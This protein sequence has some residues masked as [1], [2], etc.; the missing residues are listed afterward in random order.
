MAGML[1]T[2]NA[3]FTSIAVGA[4]LMVAVAL[5]G[6]LSILPAML[7]KL[8]DRV[9]RGRIPYLG[10]RGHRESRIWGFV[11][12][13]VLRRPLLAALLSGGALLALAAAGADAA[14]A[15]AELHRPAAVAADRPHLRADPDRVPR[16]ADAGDRRRQG[17]RRDRAAGAAGAR[18]A[19]GEGA[20]RPAR[21]RSR[22]TTE[23][24]PARTV[25]TV[26]I[27]LAGNGDNA[28]RSRRCE[29]LRND[30]IP[31]DDRCRPRHDRRGDRRDGRHARLQRADEEPRAARLRLRARPLLP[32]PARD[33][34][35]ARDPG[36]RRC[37]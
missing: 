7:S 15:A 19:A 16:R 21:C 33:L 23:V 13:R 35:V 28:R 6:S 20:R 34:P 14:H 9:D 8:G 3:I 2:G 29:T 17:G 11:L 32:A 26:S 24:N 1:F 25:A 31:R 12:D 36:R 4:M 30:V 27:P 5:I 37:C 22:S 10:R 18:G